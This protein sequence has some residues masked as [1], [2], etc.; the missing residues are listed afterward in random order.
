MCVCVSC[1]FMAPRWKGEDFHR[2][3]FAQRFFSS[4]NSWL[5]FFSFPL[6][7]EFD[8]FKLLNLNFFPSS[9]ISQELKKKNYSQNAIKDSKWKSPSTFAHSSL[10]PLFQ[11]INIKL[12]MTCLR[13]KAHKA[14]WRFTTMMREKIHNPYLMYTFLYCVLHSNRHE[15]RAILFLLIQLRHKTQLYLLYTH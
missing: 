11:A 2:I 10:L 7:N 5:K 13:N 4:G 9:S 1:V 8:F 3:L 14:A 15:M 6:W 12:W